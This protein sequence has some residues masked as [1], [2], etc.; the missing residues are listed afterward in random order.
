MKRVLL[1]LLPTILLSF[2]VYAKEYRGHFKVGNPYQIAGEWFYPEINISYQKT[3]VASW[4]GSKFHKKKTANGDIFYKNK[5]SAAHPTLPLP[6]F[7]KVINL[8]NGKK[9]EVLV[10]DRGPFKKDRII[11][12]SQRAAQKLGFFID[13]TAKVKVVF[14]ARKTRNLHKKLFG[15][16]MF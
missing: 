3:G 14:L 16:T 9:I 13:G 12:L 2:N 1:L 7:V 6:S 5:I 4:Y 8:E 11:D 10:N 15:Q